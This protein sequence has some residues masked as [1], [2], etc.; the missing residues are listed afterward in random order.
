MNRSQL[1]SR[2]AA[3]PAL[4]K[5]GADAAVSAAFSTIAGA[6]AGS[7]AVAFAGFGTCAT[8]TRPAREGTNPAAGESIAVAASKSPAFKAGK[9]LREEEAAR[10]GQRREASDARERAALV[11]EG[12]LVRAVQA[13]RSTAPPMHGTC[14]ASCWLDLDRFLLSDDSRARH[15]ATFVAEVN[16]ERSTNLVRR[17]IHALRLPET[18]CRRAAIRRTCQTA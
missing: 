5:A 1:S 11:S 4:T 18:T 3:A 10:D 15:A 7:D 12:R 2:V 17:R 16:V 14:D 13:S 9:K 8:R 6:L